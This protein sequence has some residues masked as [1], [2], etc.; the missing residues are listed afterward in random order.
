MLYQS[1]AIGIS[2][3]LLAPQLASA[4]TPQRQPSDAQ[5]KRQFN[6]GFLKGC[7]SGKTPEVTNQRGYC[8]CMVSSYNF[9]YDGQTL[10]AISRIAN[11]SGEV[12][13]ALV[14][15]MMQPE[16]KQCVARY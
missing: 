11:T 15:L 3:S 9:R 4:Q 14:N 5:L 16:A 7:L 2:L 12:A 8:S 6:D 10:S 1:L 13:P